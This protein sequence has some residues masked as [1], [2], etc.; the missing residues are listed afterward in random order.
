ME[1]MRLE[2]ERC[3]LGGRNVSALGVDAA[4][5]LAAHAQ[6]GRGAGRRDQGH[7][8]RETSRGAARA[9]CG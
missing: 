1:S 2:M 7:D 8:H 3:H 6:P 9:N 5:E 4:I